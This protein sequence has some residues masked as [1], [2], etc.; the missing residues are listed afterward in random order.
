MTKPLETLQTRN[1]LV[2]TSVVHIKTQK[3]KHGSVT[4]S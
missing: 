1:L 4:S 2:E 3:Q